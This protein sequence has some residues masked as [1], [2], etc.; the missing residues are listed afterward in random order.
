MFIIPAGTIYILSQGML[1]YQTA[2][3]G[4]ILLLTVITIPQII[5]Q[6]IKVFPNLALI[7]TGKVLRLV[8]SI[9][10]EATALIVFWM[11]YLTVLA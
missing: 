11:A 2:Y 8:V 10:M 4:V 5:W 9:A 7:R 6:G 1:D 3:I